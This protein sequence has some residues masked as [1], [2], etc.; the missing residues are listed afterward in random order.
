M[1]GGG[2]GLNLF[3]VSAV[4]IIHTAV[5]TAVLTAAEDERNTA[6]L[7]DAF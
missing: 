1:G 3:G 7:T 4:G 6:V 2:M 5:K